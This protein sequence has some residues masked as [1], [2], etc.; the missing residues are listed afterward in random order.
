MAKV[1]ANM[2]KLIDQRDV[3]L[4][5]IEALRNKVAGL[6]MAIALMDGAAQP[7][8]GTTKSAASVKNV[9]LDLLNEVG[10]TGLSA[11]GAVEL[12]NRRGI[13]LNQNSVSSTLSRF[14]QDNVV[15]YDGER[16]RLSKFVAESRAAQVIDLVRSAVIV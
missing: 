14:K 5:E 8:N 10:T 16:Y 9:L 15:V 6:E 1:S 13:T 7:S 12:A 3:L 11:A 2:Q 4:R